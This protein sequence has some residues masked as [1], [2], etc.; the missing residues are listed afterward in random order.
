M[1][2][3]QGVISLLSEPAIELRIHAL[4]LLNQLVD[5]FWTEISD[6]VASIEALSEDDSGLPEPARELAALVVSKV[7]FH[8][9]AFSESLTFALSSGSRFNVEERTEYVQTLIS[10]AI[11]AYIAQRS[12]QQ[13]ALHEQ[14]VQAEATM[15]DVISSAIPSSVDPTLEAI[16]ERMFE[17][18]YRDGEFLQALGIALESRRLDR[19]ETSIERSS[20]REDMLSF[21]LEHAQELVTDI[22]FRQD[23]LRL[24]VRLFLKS[25]QPNYLKVAQSLVALDDAVQLAATLRQLLSEKSSPEQAVVALQIC[26]DVVGTA[27]RHF[28]NRLREALGSSAGDDR[29]ASILSGRVSQDLQRDFLSRQCKADSSILAALKSSVDHRVSICH[30]AIV[31]ANSFMFAGTGIDDFLR[32]NLDWLAKASNWNKF[33]AVGSLGVIYSRSIAESDAL[34]AHYMQSDEAFTQGGAFYAMGLIHGPE[35]IQYLRE[36]VGRFES[37]ATVLHGLCLALGLTG[38]ATGDSGVYDA[39]KDILYRDDAIS[40][41]AAGL[42]MGLVMTGTASQ[43]A[44][45]EMAAYARETQHEKIIR[46]LATG[47]AAV[48]Y[49]KEQGAE[50]LIEPLVRDQDPI[51]RYGSMQCL[52]AAYVGTANNAAIRRALHVAVSDVSDDVRRAATMS[53]GFILSKDPSRCPRIVSLLA[54]SYNPHVRYGSTIAVGISSSG[55]G[56]KEA[57]DLLKPLLEDPVDF[58]RQGAYL[59]MAMVLMQ[60]NEVREPYTATFREKLEKTTGDR[61]QPVMTKLGAILAA[62]ILDAGGRNTTIDLDSM[63]GVVGMIVFLQHWF[64]YP[65]LHFFSLAVVPTHVTVLTEDLKMPRISFTSR[66]KPSLFAYP[67]RR[68]TGKKDLGEKKAVL[69]MELS[70]AAKARVKT[71]KKEREKFGGKT[72]AEMEKEEK[73][74]EQKEREQKERE[75]KERLASEPDFETLQNPARVTAEQERFIEFFS[76][77]EEREKSR[78]I[79]VKNPP[80]ARGVSGFV[81]VMDTRR[82]EPEDLLEETKSSAAKAAAEAAAAE[83]EEPKPPAPFEY[84]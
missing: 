66:S 36:A 62:G 72:S 49:G 65:F 16:V 10:E 77:S 7:Y 69:Q 58:V 34:L 76:S 50:S 70:Q 61:H 38:M 39:L 25:E 28:V 32:N 67:P 81:L 73:E 60:I 30:S 2:S 78:Y 47:L 27:K 20:S 63:R 48:V 35:K 75:E 31:M 59:G 26:F 56:D 74:R 41:E 17:R 15:A 13:A 68:E 40:G 53:L 1:S 21:A 51:L 24:L 80:F 23:L 18:C 43:T 46:G 6:A 9:G 82:G 83:A 52:A 4:E 44:V 42:A 33:S 22:S 79:P 84:P 8:L 37:N 14:Q 3:A 57:I 12:K 45:E 54:Q 55:T 5:Q 71:D 11:T 19:I 64:W 29:V